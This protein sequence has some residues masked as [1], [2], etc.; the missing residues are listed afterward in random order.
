MARADAGSQCHKTQA[1]ESRSHR[2]G[3]QLE[4]GQTSLVTYIECCKQSRGGRDATGG[5]VE[6]PDHSTHIHGAMALWSHCLHAAHVDQ[7]QANSGVQKD[8]G[9]QSPTNKVGMTERDCE[10]V[11][12]VSDRRLNRIILLHSSLRLVALMQMHLDPFANAAW[13]KRKGLEGRVV[14]TM[15]GLLQACMMA[16]MWLTKPNSNSLSASSRIR[17]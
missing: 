9:K 7:T 5:T 15:P 4:S 11:Y 17:N 1:R 3:F 12:C 8:L 16:S 6:A 13:C 14:R 10:L 2:A